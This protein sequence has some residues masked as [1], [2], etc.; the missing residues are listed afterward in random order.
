MLQWQA[1]CDT[2]HLRTSIRV[3]AAAL[4]GQYLLRERR[5]FGRASD[6]GNLHVRDHDILVPRKLLNSVLTASID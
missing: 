6:P 5:P 4:A 2:S 3:G 1:I